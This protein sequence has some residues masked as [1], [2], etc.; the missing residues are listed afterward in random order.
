MPW[1]LVR[2]PKPI[3]EQVPDKWGRYDRGGYA[4]VP[5]DDPRAIAH[6]GAV[7]DMQRGAILCQ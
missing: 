3:E 4:L 7:R 6:R 5:D 2:E 1:V